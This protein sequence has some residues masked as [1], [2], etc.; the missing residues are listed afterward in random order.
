M[1]KVLLFLSA[2]ALFAACSNLKENEFEVEGSIDKSL[3]G[4][5]VILQK[6]GGMFGIVPVDT[7]KIENGK[8]MFKGKAEAPEFHFVSVEGLQNVGIN[9]V[10]EHGS[11]EL[12][13]DKDSIQKSERGGTYNNDVLHDFMTETFKIQADKQKFE[14]NNMTAYQT[15]Q[16]KN[17][18]VTMNKLMKQHRGFDDKLN[19]YSESFI[20]ENPKAYITVLLLK[21]QAVSGRK[22]Y[23]EL[24][25]TYE[26]LDEDLKK[27]KE[28]KQ[29][30]E[31]IENMKKAEEK[32]ALLKKNEA[33]VAVGKMAPDFSAPGPDGKTI[34]LKQSL[35]KVTLIDFWASWCGPCRQENPNVVAMYNE[36]HSKG[37]NIIGVS[38]DRPN[39]ADKWKKAIAD[40]KLTWTHVSNLLE[41][42]DPI[43]QQYGVQGIPATFLLDASG[44]I[45]AK[46]LRG[47]E[48]KAKVKEL[49]G[50]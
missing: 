8:F 13:I 31:A 9:F 26:G 3:D 18:T 20:K 12:K 41:W 15:A 33:N 21:Q 7:V 2:A 30:L 50:Q 38:L 4:K 45:V 47:E 40:D 6:Q 49:L 1:K 5:N 25:K 39:D 19:N 46:N 36:L 32:T 22:T 17:D 44:K 16:G 34:S 42:N 10:L 27:L 23:A 35:G 14:K 43:A 29:L 28:G 48:L 11:I 37:L 24:K